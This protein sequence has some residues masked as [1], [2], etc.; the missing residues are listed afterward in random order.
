MSELQPQP[1]VLPGGPHH[2]LPDVG[3]L[4][5]AERAPTRTVPSARPNLQLT[6]S[7][8]PIASRHRMQC[9]EMALGES[10]IVRL[11]TLLGSRYTAQVST[12]ARREHLR[13]A[14]DDRL[15]AA[16]DLH[17]SGRS[18]L[19]A[20]VNHVGIE[21]LLKARILS[22]AGVESVATLRSRWNPEDVDSV[23]SGKSGHELRRLADKAKLKASSGSEVGFAS[24]AE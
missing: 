2:A 15:S 19:A 24:S 5:R 17:A 13:L 3:C 22:Q 7:C 18:Q 1:T 9:S 8:Q 12:N 21:C 14:A 10:R 4:R 16:A 6:F 23:F 11:F 20:Y